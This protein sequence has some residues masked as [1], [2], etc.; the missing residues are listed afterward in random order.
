M[1]KHLKIAVICDSY[2]PKINSAAIQMSELVEELVKLGHEIFLFTPSDSKFD[3]FRK[4]NKRLS[5]FY[6][7][8]PTFYLFNKNISRFLNEFIFWSFAATK[9]KKM[10]FSNIGI[11]F[12]IAYSP[13]IFS[14]KLASYIKKE[15]NISS[16]L[17][18]RDLFPRW[19][20]DLKV[21]K[22]KIIYNF[23]LYH[24][25]K[26]I[27]VFDFIG[28][29]SKSN[30]EYFSKNY[31]NHF[32]KIHILNN[33]ATI[34]SRK[35][36]IKP[37]IY[38]NKFIFLYA[39]N[40][41]EAQSTINLFEAM[42]E[43]R[44]QNILFVFIARGKKFHDLRKKCIASRMQNVFFLN[45]MSP[46]ELERYIKFSHVGFFTLNHL[47]TTHN[48]PGKFI[49]YLGYSKPVFGLV[50]KGNSLKEFI[51]Q[52]NLGVCIDKYD[53]ESIIKSMLYIYDNYDNFKNKILMRSIFKKNFSTSVI[54][55]NILNYQS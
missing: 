10:F 40:L 53:K 36:L 50:N 16:Y 2:P 48:V 31:P 15:K 42:L 41:G 5:I 54:A 9:V 1:I 17:I 26:L 45:L 25:K 37:I 13:S 43:L 55:Q 35:G 46:S 51:N 27:D 47:H 7:K 21:I 49:T 28:I 29:Q 23:L 12:I 39:G 4:V 44:E 34:R 20:W 22:L 6:I 14:Y 8:T 52:N 11:N 19:A 3:S 32:K 33:W 30:L 38:K 18:L 24:E